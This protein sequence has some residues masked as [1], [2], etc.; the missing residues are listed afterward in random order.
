MN[1]SYLTPNLIDCLD[2]PLPFFIGIPPHTWKL[3]RDRKEIAEEEILIFDVDT[4]LY[5]KDLLL[6][7]I[8][9]PAA[10]VLLEN[11]KS[12]MAKKEAFVNTPSAAKDKIVLLGFLIE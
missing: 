11:L 10:T 4:K 6:P 5:V 3:V 12:L 7:P 1:I 8:P 2:A 9:E